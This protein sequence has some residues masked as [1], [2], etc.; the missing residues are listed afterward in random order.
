MAPGVVMMS[1]E[2]G[3]KETGGVAGICSLSAMHQCLSLP[4][5]LH[6]SHLL[7][8]SFSPSVHQRHDNMTLR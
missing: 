1:W 6:F 2:S 7:S 3:G 4:L 8:L 5:S